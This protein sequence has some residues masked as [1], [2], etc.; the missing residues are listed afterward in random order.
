MTLI[1]SDLQEL[2]VFLEIDPRD[3][4]EDKKLLFLIEMASN[5]LEEILNRDFSFKARTQYYQ[6]TGTQKLLLRN[7]PVYPTHPLQPIQV[8]YDTNGFFGAGPGSFTNSSA[9]SISY[10]YGVDYTL[11][12]DQDDGISSRSGILIRINEYW[13]KPQ[14]RQAG[15]LTP[16]QADDLGSIQVQYVAGWTV[17]TLP[18]VMRWAVNLLVSKMRYIM[19]IGQEISSESYEER[20]I[21]TLGERKYYLT[22]LVKSSVM[23]SMRNWKF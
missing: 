10:T 17:D 7:R 22:S 11:K 4:S 20:A 14:V 13:T 5:W 9:T 15:L 12:I 21:S 23:A 2:K 1:L 8:T 6:G 3:I 16:F 18:A 19:P